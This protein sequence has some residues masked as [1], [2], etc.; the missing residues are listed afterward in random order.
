MS[1]GLREC[2]FDGILSDGQ[3]S[4]KEK[5][6]VD[7]LLA[8]WI[9]QRTPAPKRRKKGKQKQNQEKSRKTKNPE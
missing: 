6:K 8:N 2:D 1:G 9:V 5:E 3:L 7:D 4:V